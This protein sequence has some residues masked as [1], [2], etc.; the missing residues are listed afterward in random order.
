VQFHNAVQG[1]WIRLVGKNANG[2]LRILK[3]FA[4]TERVAELAGSGGAWELRQWSRDDIAGVPRFEVEP[5]NA[6]SATFE[7]RQSLAEMMGVTG[8]A[9]FDFITT[10]SL[11]KVTE[12]RTLQLELVERNKALLLRGIGLAPV[13]MQASMQSG[14]PVFADDGQEHVSILKSDPHH[15]AIPAYLSV[16]NSPE[17]RADAALTQAA[18]DC[19]AESQRLWGALTLDDC[20]AYGIPPLP[21]K[22]MGMPAPGALQG[23]P[24]AGGAP[25]NDG[26]PSPLPAPPEPP[27]DPLTGESQD[28]AELGL[29]KDSIA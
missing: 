22:S 20:A 21:S 1:E 4:R 29:S 16:V 24:T 23:P 8:D 10:G 6:M 2:R 26:P 15:L 9:L 13:D 5:I 17:A 19:V 18:L 7:G 3:R 28:N 14:Q 12:T 27:Q 25:P 11:K